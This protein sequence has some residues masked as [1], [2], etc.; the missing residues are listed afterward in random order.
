MTQVDFEKTKALK[1][2]QR[3]YFKLS[4]EFLKHFF[5]KIF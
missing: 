5:E 3:S 1:F 4:A 2:L